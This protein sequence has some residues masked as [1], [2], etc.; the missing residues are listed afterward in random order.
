M[1]KKLFKARREAPKQPAGKPGKTECYGVPSPVYSVNPVEYGLR[2][3]PTGVPSPAYSLSP[4]E[5][6]LLSPPPGVPGPP[7]QLQPN[8]PSPVAYQASAPE[9]TPKQVTQ[10]KTAVHPHR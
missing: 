8:S 10:P 2:S 6:G 4:V 3:P 5:Y 9:P 1:F 7:M